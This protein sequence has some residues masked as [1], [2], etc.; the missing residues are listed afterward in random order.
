MEIGF[1]QLF[2]LVIILTVFVLSVLKRFKQQ[3]QKDKITDKSVEEFTEDEPEEFKYRLDLNSFVNKALGLETIHDKPIIKKNSNTRLPNKTE[4]NSEK[5]VT[6]IE[7]TSFN[8]NNDHTITDKLHSTIKEQHLHSPIGNSSF[9][10]SFNKPSA[11]G[12]LI[13]SYETQNNAYEQINK[14]KINVFENDSLK[15]A[16]IFS[17]IISPPISLRKRKLSNAVKKARVVELADTLDSKSS[18]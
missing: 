15:K 10:P 16:I 4:T 14:R 2:W 11:D 12:V 6:E 3:K 9:G 7:N 18:A 13:H 8:N 5:I 17:E 1:T